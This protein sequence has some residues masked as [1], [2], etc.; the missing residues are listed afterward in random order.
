MIN[1]AFVYAC[2]VSLC[3]LYEWTTVAEF[4]RQPLSFYVEMCVVRLCTGGY[5][6][7]ISVTVP[8][9]SPVLFMPL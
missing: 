1:E 4:L 7:L 6:Y 8:R 5:G 9:F 3:S 2:V